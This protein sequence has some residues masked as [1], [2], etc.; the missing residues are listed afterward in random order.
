MSNSESVV[1]ISEQAVKENEID[2][3]KRRFNFYSNNT[4]NINSSVNLNSPHS[5]PQK[6]KNEEI[7]V[8]KKIGEKAQPHQ[9]SN[10]RKSANKQQN[11]TNSTP[12]KQNKSNSKTPISINNV[13][14]IVNNNYNNI[15]NP[16]LDRM[17][18]KNQK[19]FVYANDNDTERKSV[20]KKSTSKLNPALEEALNTSQRS[21]NSVNFKD[22]QDYCNSN[23]NKGQNIINRIIT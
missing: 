22:I 10:F 15:I 4:S 21:M 23:E 13:V 2:R 1:K 9:N 19:Q 11:S 5:I 8:K 20:H 14:N 16:M 12:S 6:K 17:N 18:T 7:L 3:L